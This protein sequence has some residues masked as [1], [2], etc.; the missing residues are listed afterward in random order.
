[1]AVELTEELLM[2]IAGWQV[3]KRARA[4]ASDGKVHDAKWNAPKLEGRCQGGPTL[5]KAGMI[6][7]NAVDADN[8][9]TCR[10]SREHGLICAHSVAL[11]LHIIDPKAA[12]LK[13]D[14]QAAAAEKASK[15]PVNTGRSGGAGNLVV[16]DP[17]NCLPISTEPGKGEPLE[18]HI[19]LPPNLQKSVKQGRAM[20]T[21]EGDVNGRRMPLN[22]IPKNTE[23][24]LEHRDLLLLHGLET[25]AGGVTPG[26]MMLTAEEFAG[27]LPHLIGHPNITMGRNQ[28]F[29]I[30]DE[31][32][33]P[34]LKARLKESGDIRIMAEDGSP[35]VLAGKTPW[36]VCEDRICPMSMPEG[37][38]D[39]LN[40]K[41]V[42]REKVPEFINNVWVRLAAD[43]DVDADF[44]L[45]DFVIETLTPRIH[46]H[47][48]GGMAMLDATLEC[49]YGNRRVKPGKLDDD[50]SLMLPD[51]DQPTA[52][53][54]RNFQ[55]EKRAVE[56]LQDAGFTGP[57]RMGKYRVNGQDRVL[58]F[59]AGAYPQIERQWK[60]TLEERLEASTE[61]N[62]ERVQP[63]F[64]IMPGEQW[65]DL[66]VDYESGDSQ[67]STA[68]IQQ[69]LQSGRNHGKT[70]SGKFAIVDTGAVE[71]LQESLMDCEPSQH[72]GGYRISQEQA[73][74]LN[75]TLKGL[76]A[77]GR[78]DAPDDWKDLV[79]KQTGDIELD[80]P[81]FGA[82]NDLL[83]D[84]QKKGVAWLRFLKANRFSG[85]LADEM[86]LGKTLQTLAFLAF[87]QKQR[88][89]QEQRPSLVV[90]PT[91][92]VSNW[93]DEAAK[94]TPELKVLIL[95]G[96]KRKEHFKD[97]DSHH[98]VITSYA[99]V[100]RDLDEYRKHDFENVILDEAQHIKNR[101]T[102]NARAVKAVRSKH[103]LVLT[104]T[105]MENSVLDLW[106]IFDFLMPGYLGSE[107]DFQQRYEGP[108]I[109]HRDAGAQER[110][111][112]RLK[113]FVLRR[114][115]RDVA[116]DLPDKLEKVSLCE[117]TSQQ[118][119]IYQG[120][121]EAGRKEVFG[122]VD[123]NGFQKS[124]MLILTTLLR[125]RQACCDLRLLDLPNV[126]EKTSS[127]KLDL[128]NELLEE[129][130]DGDHRVLV[131]SQFTSMLQLMRDQLDASET[132]YCYLD[133]S[134]RDRGSVVQKFQQNKSIPVFLI[135]LKAGGVGLNLTGADTVIHYDPWWNPAVEA[136]ATDR[137]HR[138]GQNKVVTSYKLIT[139]GTV[140][141]KI[142]KLQLRKKEILE[143]MLGGDESFTNALSWE[144]VQDLF[145]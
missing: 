108:I 26:V 55:M 20:M 67:F 114:L 127:G 140:E 17:K 50:E 27:L 49:Y 69:I 71:E 129:A 7:K 94:F 106:S 78:L 90:C 132:P 12:P 93:F 116:K 122:A 113:P 39:F 100:R 91:S 51:P 47:L 65:F 111:T 43:C 42:K 23:Y 133:G 5:Y 11:A 79:G 28:A 84:Y 118:R 134:T 33:R 57:D 82:M 45:D 9:C 120:L 36:A 38:E 112:R 139:K 19:I 14:K 89:T 25:A 74:F 64:K 56:I 34:K 58:G 68:D 29:Q 107:K 95:H 130:I 18:I 105:P 30:S 104:G 41:I 15:A 125:M 145:E 92:L 144:D 77:D 32:W 102:Q 96:P 128:F 83:R 142:L 44:D 48:A 37:A 81:D 141:E 135:S 2:K 115:K 21:L 110:L 99:L 31:A 3:M 126:D 98:L 13:A 124:R 101:Q 16:R 76:D 8:L 97:I 80:Y 52:F 46:L 72:S 60:V 61:K 117:L 53:R 63:R 109:K 1:M 75:E 70:A 88:S 35:A 4:Y 66:S 136:Q 6:I 103:R 87:D 86:G 10:D 22:A 131:F 40:G 119:G 137:A 138:I 62:I 121:L 85:I 59:F 123:K 54:S 73:G 143:A 24:D